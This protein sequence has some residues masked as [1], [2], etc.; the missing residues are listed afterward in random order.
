MTGH[1]LVLAVSAIMFGA[2]AVTAALARL[3][4]WLRDTSRYAVT[5]RAE[6]PATV[7]SAR[8]VQS[9]AALPGRPSAAGTARQIHVITDCPAA[10]QGAR[11]GRGR[12]P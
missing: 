1:R 11:A 7:L 8:L 6:S 3:A 10:H 5:R 2:V 4:R 12:T 9:H